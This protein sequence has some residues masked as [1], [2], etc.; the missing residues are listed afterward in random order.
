MNHGKR[1]KYVVDMKFQFKFVR[2]FILA[3]LIGS[4]VSTAVFNYLANME[5]ETLLW[6]VHVNAASTGEVLRNIFLYVNFFNII[7]VS[8]LFILTSVTMFRK[9]N[10]PIYHLNNSITAIKDG[11]LSKDIA[12][13]QQDEFSDVAHSI[14]D[15]KEQIREQFKTSQDLYLEIS[16]ALQDIDR[17]YHESRDPD[18]IE[19]KIE[20]TIRLIQGMKERIPFNKLG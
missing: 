3:C 13:R 18:Q 17:N 4:V 10:E 16:R 9:I 11:N 8:L 20:N 2:G 5:L 1:R 6:R 14:H 12:L 19:H 15:M 7:I